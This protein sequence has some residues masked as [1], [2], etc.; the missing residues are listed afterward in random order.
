MNTLFGDIDGQGCDTAVEGRTVL[1][2]AV[3]RGVRKARAKE[4]AEAMPK[5]AASSEP[6]RASG[7]RH[8][9]AASAGRGTSAAYWDG[10]TNC[11]RLIHPNGIICAI[12]SKLAA[13]Y[14]DT[15]ERVICFGTY[16]DAAAVAAR[17]ETSTTEATV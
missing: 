6:S 5:M 17:M 7:E 10:L 13:E 9:V 2:V 3:R 11:F 8:E 1:A 12:S 16:Q 4:A 14:H 15:G